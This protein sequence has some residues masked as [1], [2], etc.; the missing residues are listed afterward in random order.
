MLGDVNRDA[1]VNILDISIIAKAFGKQQGDDYWNPHADLD[2]NGA[3]NII[4]I[5][6]AAREFG[7]EWGYP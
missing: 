7:K 1:K 3:I 2:D 6:T 5:S 4:D